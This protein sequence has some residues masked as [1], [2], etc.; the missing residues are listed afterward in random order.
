MTIKGDMTI[1]GN[2]TIK[3]DMT[4]KGNVT[5]KGYM[6]IKGNVTTKGTSRNG[7]NVLVFSSFVPPGLCSI[8]RLQYEICSEFCTASNERA[9]A[10]HRGQFML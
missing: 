9:K 3:G 4:I 6:T 2:V 10:L 1:K 7:T 8:H 5:I